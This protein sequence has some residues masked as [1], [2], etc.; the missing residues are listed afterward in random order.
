MEG[1]TARQSKEKTKVLLVCPG[2]RKNCFL[3]E[4]RLKPLLNYVLAVVDPII[5]CLF[6]FVWPLPT[7]KLMVAYI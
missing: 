4:F 1:S 5:F 3:F 6:T 2:S 7:F